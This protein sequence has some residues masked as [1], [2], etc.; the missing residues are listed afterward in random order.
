MVACLSVFLWGCCAGD[1]VRL[2]PFRFS[3]ARYDERGGWASGIPSC[4]LGGGDGADVRRPVPVPVARAIAYCP[5]L[6]MRRGMVDEMRRMAAAAEC[7][8][9]SG[10]GVACLPCRLAPLFDKG[11][12]EGGG[13]N[14]VG[15]LG[16]AVRYGGGWVA[17]AVCLV[18]S[19]A[20]CSDEMMRND[21]SSC[22]RCPM[23]A[24]FPFFPI[25]IALSSVCLPVSCVVRMDCADCVLLSVLG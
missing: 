13:A 6:S 23:I 2:V 9:I 15:R 3:F 1:V 7:Y 12:G 22:F 11:S 20:G 21:G 8:Q 19:R 4:L 10:G 18:L 24:V 5:C 25:S 14:D 16:D 17:R